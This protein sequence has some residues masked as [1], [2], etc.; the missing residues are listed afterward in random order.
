MI[1]LPSLRPDAAPV[2]VLGYPIE[3]VLAEELATAIL[4]GAANTCVR[5]Y[6]DIY[7]LTGRDDLIHS[8]VRALCWTQ[9]PGSA[10]SRSRRCHRLWTILAELREQTYRAYRTALGVDGAE[11]PADSARSSR[12]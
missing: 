6:A 9:L 4:F 8:A 3:T 5:D 10:G 2:R 12:Q 11:L 7:T 1:E